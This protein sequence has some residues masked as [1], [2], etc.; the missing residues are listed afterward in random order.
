MNAQF[1]VKDSDVYVFVSIRGDPGRFHS[2]AGHRCAPGETGHE[3]DGWTD[4][5]RYRIHVAPQPAHLSVKE[6]VF[7]FNKFP[8]VDVLLGPK[9]KSQAKSWVSMDFNLGLRQIAGAALGLIPTA[10]HSVCQRQERPLCRPRGSET[11]AGWDSACWR[12]RRHRRIPLRAR[13]GCQTVL[14]VTEGR[15]YRRP[16]QERRRGVGRQH[17]G[18]GGFACRLAVHPPEAL[19]RGLWLTS[20]MRARRCLGI[21]AIL[22]KN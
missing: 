3:D 15:S 9:M 5:R 19:N 10:R 11:S 14:K 4:V 2:S 18:H 17:R 1:A 16:H 20:T 7:P 8:G 6:A 13:R 12:Q 21:E 22:K